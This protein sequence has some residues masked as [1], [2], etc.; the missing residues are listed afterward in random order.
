MGWG[1]LVGT[2]MG[3]QHGMHARME[4]PTRG[5]VYICRQD[6]PLGVGLGELIS[7]GSSP[8]WAG[9]QTT[10]GQPQQHTQH[11]SQHTTPLQLVALHIQP[12]PATAYQTHTL[13]TRLAANVHVQTITMDELREGIAPHK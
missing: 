13:T 1:A 6:A 3:R 8:G 5:H 2:R 9:G 4:V 10:K 11:C 12:T 7:P